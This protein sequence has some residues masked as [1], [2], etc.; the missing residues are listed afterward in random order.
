VDLL[1]FSYGGQLVMRFLER[2][3]DRVR[4]L[5]LASTTAY[6]DFAQYL[7]EWPEYLR[8]TATHDEDAL[9]DNPDLSD[10]EKT[11]LSAFH[12]ANTAIWN[13]E[14]LPAY[15]ALLKGVRFSGDWMSR[16]RAGALHSPRPADPEG[17]LRKSGKPTLILHGA[18]DM[19]FPV[20]LARR[21][22]AAVPHSN[23]A[24][25]GQAGHMAHFEQPQLWL[26]ALRQFLHD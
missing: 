12:T 26:D 3:P 13:L 25:I 1:G 20:Q 6:S 8:R 10:Q 4:R 15:L 9:F 11:E 22:H 19:G 2:Y 21:L 14:L 5:V 18:Q 16:W 24:V 23:L 17:L 7:D